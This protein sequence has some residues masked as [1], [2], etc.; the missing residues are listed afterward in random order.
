MLVPNRLL[1]RF[2]LPLRHCPAMP[3]DGNLSHWPAECRLPDLSPIDGSSHIPSF[4]QVWMGWNQ[5]GLYVA[6]RVDGR[7][8]PFRCDPKQYWKGDN[9][10]LCTD[11]RDTRDI[12]RGSRYCQQFYF[13]P[14]GGGRDGQSPIAGVAKVP[15][16]SE[17]APQVAN[18]LLQIA[19]QRSGSTYTLEAHIPA[20]ALSG[21]DPDEHRRIGIY[22]MLE[23][24]EL[25]QQ[26]LTV[27]DDLNWNIDPS[28][29]AT[30]VLTSP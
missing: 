11:M 19:S 13:L 4:G 26:Y 14:A 8:S 23:D 7:N 29:W 30:A 9:L 1:F 15:R 12:K 27:G 3:I 5:A 10:R 6:I 2:E 21:F 24:V 25:G 18:D 22:Y 16:A 17:N 28:T 20:A